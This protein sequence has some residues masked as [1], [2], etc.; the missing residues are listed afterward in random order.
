MVLFSWVSFPNIQYD[1]THSLK[2]CH[3]HSWNPL[4]PW[5]TAKAPPRSVILTPTK[6]QHKYRDNKKTVP[7]Q[8]HR[9]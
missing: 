2:Y 7:S 6:K 8:Q 3:S 5:N 1:N 9:P 4:N